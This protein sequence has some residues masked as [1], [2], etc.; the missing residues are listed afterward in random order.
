ME[1]A[2]I[3]YIQKGKMV[4]LNKINV[5]PLLFSVSVSIGQNSPPTGFHYSIPNISPL[6]L[7]TL[8]GFKRPHRF[9]FQF[10][11]NNLNLNLFLFTSFFSVN[12]AISCLSDQVPPRPIRTQQN[13]VNHQKNLLSHNNG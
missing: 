1:Q 8:D 13:K 9:N 3:H 11:L 2:F 10:H 6:F 5:F 4:S 7:M 12:L